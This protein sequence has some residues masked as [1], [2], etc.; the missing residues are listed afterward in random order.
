LLERKSPN[1][2]YK[3][4]VCVYVITLSFPVFLAFLR[5]KIYLQLKQYKKILIASFK[6][7]FISFQTFIVVYSFENTVYS[8]SKLIIYNYVLGTIT[9]YKIF[10]SLP[11]IYITLSGLIFLT[12]ISIT[13]I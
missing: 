10:Y 9:N 11:E 1:L 13:L 4:F 12:L 3:V 8:I 7:I 5:L 2:W 6:E